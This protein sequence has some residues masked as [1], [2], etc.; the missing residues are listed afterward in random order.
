MVPAEIGPL[1]LSLDHRGDIRS[2]HFYFLQYPGIAGW[3]AT[4]AVAAMGLLC[5]L[6]A[7]RTRS[8][9]APVAAHA[10]YNAMF[11]LVTFFGH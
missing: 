3:I 11:V 8:L 1:S 6:W 7:Q 2:Y 10:A 9:R 5:A 4:A